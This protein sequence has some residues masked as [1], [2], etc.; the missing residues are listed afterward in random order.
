MA[1]GQ[2]QS[3]GVVFLGATVGVATV[4]AALLVAV[5]A[6]FVTASRRRRRTSKRGGSSKRGEDPGTDPT[7]ST[8]GAGRPLPLLPT[9]VNGHIE[10][11]E[12]R[13]A[14][15]HYVSTSSLQHV[16]PATTP[17][18]TGPVPPVRKDS[19]ASNVQV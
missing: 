8:T 3:L 17:Q 4:L 9:P 1:A 10:T 18:Q 16:R 6:C 19:R 15:N 11:F 14:N 2:Q 7:G 13:A 12:R 5:V